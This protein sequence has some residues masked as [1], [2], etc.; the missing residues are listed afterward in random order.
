MLDPVTPRV[1]SSPGHR[2]PRE[3]KGE[4]IN[5]SLRTRKERKTKGKERKRR[6]RERERNDREEGKK[7]LTV[8]EAI[9]LQRTGCA[10]ETIVCSVSGVYRY[11]SW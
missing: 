1:P 8:L 3:Q 7:L 9:V 6:E 5:E 10:Q 4:P 11:R 2:A